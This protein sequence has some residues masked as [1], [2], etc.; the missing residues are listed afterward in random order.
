MSLSFPLLK[1]PRHSI[2]ERLQLDSFSVAS[3]N[4]SIKFILCRPI[5]GWVAQ[6]PVDFFLLSNVDLRGRKLELPPKVPPRRYTRR[7]NEQLGKK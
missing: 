5:N 2:R 1:L 7:I 3:V 4:R 6:L